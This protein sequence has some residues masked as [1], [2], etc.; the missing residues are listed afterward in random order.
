VLKQI[1]CQR[2]DRAPPGAV[3]GAF[4]EVVPLHDVL[5]QPSLDVRFVENQIMEPT[6]WPSG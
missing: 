6:T 3:E 2:I 1:H 4:A 5:V